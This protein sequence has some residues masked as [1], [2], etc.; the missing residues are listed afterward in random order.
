MYLPPQGKEMVDDACLSQ[1]NSLKEPGFHL[2]CVVHREEA[3]NQFSCGSWVHTDP[4]LHLHTSTVALAAFVANHRVLLLTTCPKESDIL[5]P[6]DKREATL[7]WSGQSNHS[8]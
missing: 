5:K 6:R 1:V 8:M 2:E 3:Q 7:L 4:V